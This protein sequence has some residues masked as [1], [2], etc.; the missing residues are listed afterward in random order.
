MDRTVVVLCGPPGAGKT[1]TAHASGLHVYD[2]DDRQWTS[3]AHFRAAL[4]DLGR[5]PDARAVVIRWAPTSADRA[6]LA[7]QVQATH[8]WVITVDRDE[9]A[10]RITRR[11]RA[12]ATRTLAGLDR[13][14][15][16]HERADGVADFP[17]WGAIGPAKTSREW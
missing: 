14:L 4:D 9:L 16:A 15:K 1:T 7:R 6:R 11:G 5:D 12:D 13:W 2:R 17:G 10:R 3:D 8:V